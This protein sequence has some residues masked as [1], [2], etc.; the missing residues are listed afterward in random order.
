MIRGA[1]L[2]RGGIFVK[3]RLCRNARYRRCNT[4][5]LGLGDAE[6]RLSIRPS[7]PCH[8]TIQVYNSKA[9]GAGG[10]GIRHTG[11]LAS[12]KC[13]ITN[14]QL[15]QSTTSATV[16]RQCVYVNVRH[17]ENK[18]MGKYRY[19]LLKIPHLEKQALLQGWADKLGQTQSLLLKQHNSGI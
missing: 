12:T 15:G 4:V 1:L 18:Q 6:D 8:E 9:V 14:L 19:D 5:I 17:K 2:G 11:A 13:H 10:R 16:R 3:G 7:V